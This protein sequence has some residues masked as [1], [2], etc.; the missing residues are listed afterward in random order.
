MN[1]KPKIK[2]KIVI[3]TEDNSVFIEKMILGI[4]PRLVKN[5][6]VHLYLSKPLKTMKMVNAEVVIDSKLNYYCKAKDYRIYKDVLDYCELIKADSLFIAR[7][8]QPEILLSELKSRSS[9]LA[10]TSSIFGLQD[11]FNSRA[12]MNTYLELF[13]EPSFQHLLLFSLIGKDIKMPDEFYGIKKITKLFDPTY[14]NPDF[15]KTPQNKAR[16][17]LGL[18]Q[19]VFYLLYFGSMY[20]GKGIDILYSASKL[21]NDKNIKI[22]IASNPKTI[23]FEFSDKV[24]QN[25]NN[26][27]YQSGHMSEKNMGYIFAAANAIILPYRK[28]YENGTSGVFVQAALAK[29]PVIC[30]NFYPFKDVCKKYKMGLIFKV[31]NPESLAK[32]IIK[33]KNHKNKFLDQTPFLNY[34][35]QIQRWDDVA[36]E[37]LKND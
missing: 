35:S 28:T 27:I 33:V 4:L 3:F 13:K 26:I 5:N 7:L 19:D 10:I 17:K 29:K 14:E 25:K 9:K 31:E 12:R 30:P 37:I 2:K 32:S 21:I 15:Y 20:Y 6:E 23:N 1:A 34:L 8:H 16:V 24:L 11:V 22:I 18:N 36:G